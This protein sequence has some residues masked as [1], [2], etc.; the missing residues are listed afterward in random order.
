VSPLTLAP[1]QLSGVGWMA[2]PTLA[3][4]SWSPSSELKMNSVFFGV[5]PSDARRWKKVPNCWL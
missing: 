1:S 5:I 4:T 3:P 2:R